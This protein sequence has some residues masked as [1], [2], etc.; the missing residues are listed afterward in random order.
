MEQ[1]LVKLISGNVIQARI[2]NFN[3]VMIAK[4]TDQR[5][6]T[7]KKAIDMGDAYIREV[8]STR[9]GTF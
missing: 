6:V 5:S 1:E 4:R 3:K 2:D 7:F 8:E 9:C